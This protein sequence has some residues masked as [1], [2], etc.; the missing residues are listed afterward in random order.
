MEIRIGNK[1][2]SNYSD[3]SYREDLLKLREFMIELG[4]DNMTLDDI[5]T[6]WRDVSD[7]ACASFLSIPKNKEDL[8]EILQ[9]EYGDD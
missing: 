7:R 6:M 5:D 1:V 9:R 2:F 4:Y 8:L 3:L